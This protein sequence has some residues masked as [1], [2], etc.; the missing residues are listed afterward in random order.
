M[1]ISFLFL[2]IVQ[3]SIW[4]YWKIQEFSIETHWYLSCFGWGVFLALSLKEI[5]KYFT[6]NLAN[7]FCLLIFASIAL[8][9]SGFK[10]LFVIPF[11]MT[12]GNKFVF[13]G[14]IWAIFIASAINIKSWANF[15]VETKLL[16]KLGQW[17][18]SIYLFHWLI[19]LT[20][21]QKLPIN[22]FTMF[23]GLSGAILFGALVYNFVERPIEIFRH[24]LQRKIKFLIEQKFYKN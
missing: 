18:Y 22:F 6:K 21:I 2:L 14:L 13:I 7:I 20:I 11:D 16:K 4:P 9:S 3:Q 24:N 10:N 19:Y 12:F 17:S 8:I 23:I 5:E 1:T 15:L